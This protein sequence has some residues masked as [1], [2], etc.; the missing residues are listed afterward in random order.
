MI[1]DAI[2]LRS[3]C[4]D[5]E[6][7]PA[8]AIDT[9]FERSRTYYPR[10]ALIQVC[11]TERSYLIDPLAI[12]D[13]EPLFAVL[14]NVNIVKI[15]HSSSEDLELFYRMAETLPRPLFDTQIAAA[16]AGFRYGVGYS[17]LVS[18][19][20]GISLPK[21][22]TR[23]NWLQRPLTP[24]QLRY[25]ALDVEYLPEVHRQVSERLGRQGRSGWV[26]EDC[27]R[28]QNTDRFEID[29]ED[30]YLRGKQA[31]RLAPRNLAVLRALCAWREREARR[32]DL[33]RNFV[34]RDNALMEIAQRIPSQ[35]DELQGIEGLHPKEIRRSGE[36]L[37]D[38]ARS[39]FALPEDQLPAPLPDPQSLREHAGLLSRLKNAVQTKAA[40]LEVAPELLA[41]NRILESLVRRAK[42]DGAP[43]LPPELEGWRKHVIG[44]ELLSIVR[45]SD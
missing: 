38:I 15:L 8:L 45:Q 18:E 11:D 32:R 13:L 36:S 42:L 2:E 6:A 34:I 17:S 5:W 22:Q 40:E 35:V 21:D 27:D 20:F 16:C 12:A 41:Q 1:Q 31:W 7:L 9:E 10:P 29:P 26:E 44:E 14:D 30:T 19:L 25:A 33:P 3:I 24:S 4:R 28:L 39:A 37:I 23:S 43:S